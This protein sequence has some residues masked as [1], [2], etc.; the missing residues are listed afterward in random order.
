MEGENCWSLPITDPPS[1]FRDEA[2]SGVY[3]FG[4]VKNPQAA[5]QALVL[6]PPL[7]SHSIWARSLIASFRGQNRSSHLPV[8]VLFLLLP[9]ACFSAPAV[10][11][12]LSAQGNGLGMDFWLLTTDPV[13]SAYL[14]EQVTH[15]PTC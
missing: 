10:A 11:G 13:A 8:S 4:G 5:P 3:V 14:Q 1:V 9:S 6:T 7:H 12:H 15:I 2:L